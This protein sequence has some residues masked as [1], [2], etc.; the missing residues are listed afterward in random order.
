MFKKT[1]SLDIIDLD[2]PTLNFSTE[3]YFGR[4]ELHL[5]SNQELKLIFQFKRHLIS[6]QL[7]SE[8]ELEVI[9]RE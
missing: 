1:V 9:N 4:F 8:A 2:A 5:S 3:G 7:N 6:E